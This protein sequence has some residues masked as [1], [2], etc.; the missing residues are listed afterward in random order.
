M[1]DEHKSVS[2]ITANRIFE[3]L[4]EGLSLIQGLI[5]EVVAAD[6]H[7][8]TLEKQ[9]AWVR[10]VGSHKEIE[11]VNDMNALEVVFTRKKRRLWSLLRS[12]M[13]KPFARIVNRLRVVRSKLLSI[14]SYLENETVEAHRKVCISY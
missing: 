5:Y 8:V 1:A 9:R 12:P 2:Q 14:L 13:L 3:R 6:V 4:R 11:N 10:E 7:V